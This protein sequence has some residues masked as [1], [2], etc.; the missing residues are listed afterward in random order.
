MLISQSNN[1]I[2]S[3]NSIVEG[4]WQKKN[5]IVN[6]LFI[7]CMQRLS[8]NLFRKTGKNTS[9]IVYISSEHSGFFFSSAGEQMY[10]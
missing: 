1:F 10:V 5:H 2:E 6:N 7:I 3:N 8:V 4:K 9:N